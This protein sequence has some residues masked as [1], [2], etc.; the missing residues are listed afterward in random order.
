MTLQ[1]RWYVRGMGGTQKY[2]EGRE[3]KRENSEG[4]KTYIKNTEVIAHSCVIQQ[5][6]NIQTNSHASLNDRDMF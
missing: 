3:C 5:L 2:D 1:N 6:I 4:D